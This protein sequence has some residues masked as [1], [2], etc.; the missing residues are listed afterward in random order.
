METWM[1]I[2]VGVI[3]AAVIVQ[4]IALVVMSVAIVKVGKRI[5]EISGDLR[6][7]INPILSRIHSI[8]EE[9]QPRIAGVMADAAEMTHLARS[10]AQR[11]DHI[12]AES[13][14]RLRLQLL[15]IDQ[16]VTGALEAVEETGTKV[17]R[18]VWAPVR[19]VTAVVRGI[20]TGLEFYRGNRRRADGPSGED[21]NLFI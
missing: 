5:E 12:V 4:T 20:Q 9:T 19:S 11:I 16:M 3:A 13:L 6:G 21:D 14:E 2:F 17:K 18:T 8:V 15:H 10:Q 1:P 7:R